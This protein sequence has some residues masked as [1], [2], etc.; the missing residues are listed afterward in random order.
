MKLHIFNLLFSISLFLGGNPAVVAGSSG[1]E[2]NHHYVELESNYVHR[3]DATMAMNGIEELKLIAVELNNVKNMLEQNQEQQKSLLMK[4][5]SLEGELNQSSSQ[6]SLLRGE[7]A[8]PVVVTQACCGQ[9]SE[10]SIPSI[11]LTAVAVLVTVLGVF[12]AVLAFWGYKE[13]RR[14]IDKKVTQ[15]TEEMIHEKFEN[16]EFDSLVSKKLEEIAY[17]NIISGRELEREQDE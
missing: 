6:V 14:N 3:A 2:S 17:G 10:S 4:V 9:E 11:V 16:D 8:Y 7:S 13:A 12:I 15:R 1:D 5:Q